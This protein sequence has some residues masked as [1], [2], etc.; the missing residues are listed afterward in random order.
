M[1]YIIS[2]DD[3]PRWREMAYIII[4]CFNIC[5]YNAVLYIIN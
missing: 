5:S 2:S 3:F 4:F 1:T